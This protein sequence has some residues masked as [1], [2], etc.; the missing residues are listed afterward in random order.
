MSVDKSRLNGLET[1]WKSERKVSAADVDWLISLAR[2]LDTMVAAGN[3]RN[4]SRTS[5]EKL[6]D[7]IGGLF[8]GRPF[9]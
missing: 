9:P 4:A 5:S 8:G 2:R 6:S 3:L 1:R 7:A